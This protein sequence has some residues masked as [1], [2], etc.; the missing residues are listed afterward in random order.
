MNWDSPHSTPPPQ[1]SETPSDRLD[2]AIEREAQGFDD[3][4]R[5][6]AATARILEQAETLDPHVL[7]A[8][9]AREFFSRLL[10]ILTIADERG[11]TA[12]S[13]KDARMN[14]DVLRCLVHATDGQTLAELARKHGVPV[15]TWHSR[16]LAMS[17]DLGV[18]YTRTK[19]HPLSG[20]SRP[21]NTTQ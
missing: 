4:A 16:I 19:R 14:L 2:D 11:L 3:R 17:R 15:Q 1:Y 12:E 9:L 5:F 18:P 6:R 13:V 20:Q 7:A 10:T 21:A 8:P